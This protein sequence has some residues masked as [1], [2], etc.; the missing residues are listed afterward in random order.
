MSF[1]FEPLYVATVLCLLVAGAE[2]LSRQKYFS[3]LGSALIAILATAL[4]ANLGLLPSSRNA[5]ALYD[6]IFTYIAP[7]AIFSFSS[8]SSCAI[9]VRRVCQCSGFFC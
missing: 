4:L 1:V 2:W 5:P 3:Y 9:C 8:M 7:L 6:G